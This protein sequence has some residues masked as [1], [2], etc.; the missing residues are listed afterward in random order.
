MPP[1]RAQATASRSLTLALAAAIC[2]VSASLDVI[3]HLKTVDPAKVAAFEQDP[4]R[5][6][7]TV[8][9]PYAD[10]ERPVGNCSAP[11]VC[12]CLCMHRGEP[13]KDFFKR[14]IPWGYTFGTGDCESGFE[15][16][17]NEDGTFR[18]CHLRACTPCL[19]WRAACG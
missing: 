14:S 11:N 5:S 19:W 9:D 18:T 12:E 2:T 7:V 10:M 4:C 1:L 15:G 17:R 3:R 8:F 16:L 6:G 13:W